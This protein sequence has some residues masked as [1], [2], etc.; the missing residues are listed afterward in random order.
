MKAETLKLSALFVDNSTSPQDLS[1]TQLA[2]LLPQF[3]PPRK[4]RRSLTDF[5]VLWFY[6]FLDVT[7]H[8][9]PESHKHPSASLRGSLIWRK[10]L[11]NRER[12][13]KSNP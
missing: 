13:M 1:E 4:L 8:F 5:L 9:P 3:F 2:N 10:L 12:L 7:F 11:Y 6:V